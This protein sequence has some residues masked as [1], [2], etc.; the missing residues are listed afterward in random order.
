MHRQEIMLTILQSLL[1]MVLLLNMKYS[2]WEAAA[3]FFLWVVQFGVPDL[4]EEIQWAYVALIV[5]AFVQVVRG[6]RSV[7]AFRVFAKHWRQRVMVQRSPR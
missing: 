5:L 3:I 4:R 1:G 7:D 2:A 6:R